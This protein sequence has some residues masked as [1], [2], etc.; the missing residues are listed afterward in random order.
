MHAVTPVNVH[1]ESDWHGSRHGGSYVKKSTTPVNR[2]GRQATRMRTCVTNKV[3][4]KPS[5]IPQPVAQPKQV[6]PVSSRS[7]SPNR[8]RW[9]PPPGRSTKLQKFSWQGSKGRLE[10]NPTID[11]IVSDDVDDEGS[12]T[13]EHDKQK[14]QSQIPNVLKEQDEKLQNEIQTYEKRI[15][16]L[17]ENVGMLKEKA[18]NRLNQEQADQLREDINSSIR[19]LEQ[20][21]RTTTST[22]NIYPSRLSH[23]SPPLRDNHRSASADEQRNYR[24]TSKISFK[25]DPLGDRR[26]ARSTTPVRGPIYLNPDRERLLISLSESEADISQITKQ[27]SSV[28]DILT[29]LKL[30]DQ[31][32]SF[33]VEQL[34]QH[35]NQ[36][37]HLIEQ[38]EYSNNKLKDFIR[39]QYHLEAE[40][41]I[42]NEKNDT[43]LTRIH[44][45]ESENG[46]I[47]RLLLDRENDNIA[48]Q[49]ELERIRTHAIGFDTMKT[50][51]EQNRAH[52]QRELYA[53]EGEIN[54]LQCG[55]RSLERDLQR[56]RHQCDNLHRSIR[57]TPMFPNASSSTAPAVV[58]KTKGLTVE[59]LQAQLMD[60]DRQIEEL[61]RQI[62][63]DPNEVLVDAQSEIVRL[64]TKLE[65]AER[66]VGEYKEQLHTQ[67][68][69]ASVDN[70]KTHLSEID[71]EKMRVRLQKRLEE[72]EPLP[73]YLRQ[74]EM[75][76]QELETR[77]LEQDRRLADQSSLIHELTSK[78]STQNQI[79]DRI[80]DSNYSFDD[81]YRGLQQ[82]I[83][84]LQRQM[85]TLEEDNDNLLRN[86]SAKEEALRNTQS[87]LNAKSYELASM[88]KQISLTQTDIKAREDSF[89]SKERLFQQRISDLE[90][91]ISKL[92]LEC[93]QLKREKDEVERR[94]TSQLG[95]LRD[96]L[97][98]SN[99]NNRSMQNYVN[100]LK[101]TYASVFND[102]LPP[103][104][105]TTSL[106][107]F[108][109][110][111]SVYP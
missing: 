17:I 94:Y 51:L 47:R 84:G 106:T 95:E 56:S 59:K 4:T 86:L 66:L 110:A 25:D 23:S 76:N 10:I 109:K 32:I 27:L 77:L 43:I 29:K 37:L 96:K 54:R 104:F 64:R 7:P 55:L 49:T 11:N 19:N 83:D 72:L 103:P 71:F 5:Q 87:R 44:E 33:E 81:D 31:P 75:K 36:L 57:R 41:G 67:T 35:R 52:L 62:Y 9:V 79:I 18:R 20:S 14:Q 16:G 88:N 6:V 85:I 92:R 102:A 63:A 34:R 61:E 98:Q 40:H 99:N 100:S 69:K 73:E 101:T 78:M 45:L 108:T 22:A 58:A 82:K 70:S 15:Q 93:T 30:D 48:L 80:K 107:Q 21:Q 38:F 28:K 91:Q 105:T 42:I 53:K 2:G 50:S 89:G 39:H 65:H 12:Q 74:A 24:A 8:D 3:K 111:P 13:N 26:R 1:V 97:E 90:Q 46:Q 60:R 68:L